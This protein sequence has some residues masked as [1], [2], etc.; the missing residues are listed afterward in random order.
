MPSIMTAFNFDTTSFTADKPHDA[1]AHLVS[2]PKAVVALSIYP[3]QVFNTKVSF[4]SA[5]CTRARAARRCA[6]PPAQRLP[7]LGH[8]RVA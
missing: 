3:G 5:C 8:E 4:V 6:S 7:V 1:A 2:G